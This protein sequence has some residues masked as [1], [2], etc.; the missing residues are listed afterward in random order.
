MAA[1]ISL[2]TAFTGLQ[3]LLKDISDVPQATFVQWCEF[4][5]EFTYRYLVGVDPER[6][7]KEIPF[8]VLNGVDTY[9]IN[10]D[11]HDMQ[12]WDTGFF[13]TDGN[14]QNTGMRLPL[15]SPGNGNTL[16]VNSLGG[17]FLGFVSEGY[18]INGNNFVFTPLPTKNFLLIERY[19]PN[20]T[21]LD[22]ITQYFTLDGTS[23]G[24]PIIPYE[25]LQYL[26]R[27]LAGQYMIWDEEVGAESY[28]DARYVRALDELCENIRRQPQTVPMLDFSQIY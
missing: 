9:S 4:I 15:T 25:Y 12:T 17:N 18:Y 13:I 21:P 27:A 11:F 3:N 10:V 19:I 26:I 14:G 6:F 8:T 23:T 1:P 5:Q 7:I 28:A 20:V 16:A 22:S 24:F 2:V